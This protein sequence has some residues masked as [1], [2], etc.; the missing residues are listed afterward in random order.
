MLWI[1]GVPSHMAQDWDWSSQDDNEA[2]W[3]GDTPGTEV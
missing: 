1:W 2:G 3:K